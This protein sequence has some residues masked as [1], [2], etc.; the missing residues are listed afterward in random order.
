MLHIR[1]PVIDD[2][3]AGHERQP[4]V[5]HDERRPEHRQQDDADERDEEDR[6]AGRSDVR[7]VA[8]RGHRG[9]I[10]VAPEDLTG[11]WART[12]ATPAK[13]VEPGL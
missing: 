6:E 10:A 2:L 13:C 7:K 4:R 1:K 5:A 3:A 12:I 8:R 11:R 9:M